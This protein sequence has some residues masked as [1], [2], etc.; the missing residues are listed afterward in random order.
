M[1]GGS[2]VRAAAG[3]RGISR[4]AQANERGRSGN[5]PAASV[6][7]RRM[8]ALTAVGAAG[9]S[10]SE[11]RATPAKR[12]HHRHRYVSLREG[13]L[14]HGG[15]ALRL[16]AQPRAW[17]GP[18][19]ARLISSSLRCLVQRQSEPFQVCPVTGRST[20]RTFPANSDCECAS[21]CPPSAQAQIPVSPAFTSL[22]AGRS[23]SVFSRARRPSR[24][25]GIHKAGNQAGRKT[26][27]R[28]L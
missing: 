20:D 4:S 18:P 9:P 21:V 28:D 2:A 12:R 1:S 8:K 19:D 3:E 16:R 17:S 26:N 27:G 25:L 7:Q 13:S 6:A 11:R 5:A 23:P 10:S 24:C 15:D 22:Q 14:P